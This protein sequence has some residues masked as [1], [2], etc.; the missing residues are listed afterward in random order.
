M[1]QGYLELHYDGLVEFGW[2]AV[3]DKPL[4]SDY[5]VRELANVICWADTLRRYADAGRAEYAVQVA[6]HVNGEKVSVSPGSNGGWGTRVRNQAAGQL[7]HGVTAMPRYSLDEVS[8]AEAL[9][10]VLEHDLCNAA[11]R[12]FSDD[13]LGRFRICCKQG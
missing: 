8:D 13:D 9:L 7:T 12:A 6:V 11:G 3:I 1:H 2:L 4:Y 5:A 10:S